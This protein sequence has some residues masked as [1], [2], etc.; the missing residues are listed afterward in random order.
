MLLPRVLDAARAADGRVLI[1][2]GGWDFASWY[3][4]SL[5]LQL[6][7]RGLDARMLP[8]EAVVV[9][10]HRIIDDAEPALHLLVA[11][12]YEVERRDDEPGL[13]RIAYWSSVT[14]EQVDA[15]RRRVARLDRAVERGRLS[16]LD[17]A[18]DLADEGPNT[19][20]DAVAW[21]LAVYVVE[22]GR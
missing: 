21:R 8:A 18:L 6:E 13:R 9:G 3:T 11:M 1:E 12:D 16:E 15:F 2:N 7:R 14:D 5:V 17:R 19:Y 20:D 10:E 22:R 4:R